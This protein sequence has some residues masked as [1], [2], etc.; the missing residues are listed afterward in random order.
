MHGVY[1]E[2][3]TARLNPTSVA[4]RPALPID[5]RQTVGA[6]ATAEEEPEILLDAGQIEPGDP[7]GDRVGGPA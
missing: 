3:H 2:R 6:T 5:R 1:S 7:D 4:P